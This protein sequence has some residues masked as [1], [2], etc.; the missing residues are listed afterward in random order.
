MRREAHLLEND[1]FNGRWGSE[2]VY[3]IL[4]S[5]WRA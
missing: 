3:A 5:E 4:A 1:F 2:F